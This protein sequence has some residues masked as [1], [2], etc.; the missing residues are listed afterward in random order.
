MDHGAIVGRFSGRR[1]FIRRGADPV[2]MHGGCNVPDLDV[3]ATR[4]ARHTHEGKEALLL[5]SRS[6]PAPAGPADRK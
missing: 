2:P 6:R 5:K 1:V 3:G 4:G